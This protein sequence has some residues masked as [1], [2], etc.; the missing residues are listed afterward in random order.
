[1]GVDTERSVRLE[2]GRNAKQAVP[3]GVRL[4]VFLFCAELFRYCL[5]YVAVFTASGATVAL[6][7]AFAHGTVSKLFSHFEGTRAS[8]AVARSVVTATSVLGVCRVI[9]AYWADLAV[10]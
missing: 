8:I 2:P 7:T 10:F 9:K 6:V 5:L 1:M 4:P 3:R